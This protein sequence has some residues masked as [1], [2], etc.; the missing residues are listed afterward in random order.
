[1]AVFTRG[2][3]RKPYVKIAIV[4]L[5]A[6]CVFGLWMLGKSRQKS[7]D[8]KNE[9]VKITKTISAEYYGNND[10]K[11]FKEDPKDTSLKG[12]ASLD[13]IGEKLDS[14]EIDVAI[15]KV[16]DGIKLI[17]DGKK[18][19]II[20]TLSLLNREVFSDSNLSNGIRDFAGKKIEIV[21][22][23]P[24]KSNVDTESEKADNS[25]KKVRKKRNQKIRNNSKST[26]KSLEE[27]VIGVL[28]SKDNVRIQKGNI[29]TVS[30]TEDVALNRREIVIGSPNDIKT[31]GSK[32]RFAT[33]GTLGDLWQNA[34]QEDLPEYIMVVASKFSENRNGEIDAV[35]KR[36]YNGKSA[37]QERKIV[38]YS[39]S[40]RGTW[41]ARQFLNKI[42]AFA[43]DILRKSVDISEYFQ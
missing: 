31:L 22:G 5:I 8:S 14:G 17:N 6:A 34:F 16:S 39:E 15:L 42:K 11:L 12:N 25:R 13:S 28:A 10:S 3:K 18:F 40:N 30:D 32:G 41:L 20:G 35:A 9:E 37:F 26:V 23:N 24:V 19:K 2:V 7:I 33:R 21:N 27:M 1:M 43:P 36:F 38:D 29:R 4:V